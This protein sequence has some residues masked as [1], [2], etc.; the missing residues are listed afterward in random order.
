MT[1]I[2]IAPSVLAAD[3]T[4]L[5]E[6]IQ[7]VEKAGIDQIHIDIMDGRFVPNISMGPFVVEAIKRVTDVPLDVHLMIVEPEK[8]LEAF[9]KAGAD[10]LSVHVET[11]PHLHRTLQHMRDLGV[12]PGV[13]INPH[14]PAVAISEILHL[15]D[16]VLVMTVNPGF[17][18]QKF[19]TEVTPKISHIRTMLGDRPVDI[20]VDGGIDQNT[21]G[22][23]AR[24]GA[25]VFI[26]GSSIFK[27]PNGSVEGVK[28]LH[29]ALLTT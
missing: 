25:N 23:A 13:A 10:M 7:T 17:G 19:L 27:A 4:R 8:Y 21:I 16:T 11:C 29:S 24:A 22:I 26:A 9:V 3:F 1:S 15:V 14:T 6:E 12:K 28:T 2:K 18:G 5:G 20:E